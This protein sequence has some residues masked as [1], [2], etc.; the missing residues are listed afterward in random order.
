MR[1]RPPSN[2]LR[3]CYTRLG[4][5]LLLKIK[6]WAPYV[7]IFLA[8]SLKL[9]TDRANRVENEGNKKKNQNT[10]GVRVRCCRTTTERFS[11][12]SNVLKGSK[13]EEMFFF[14]FAAVRW[15]FRTRRGQRRIKD[16]YLFAGTAQILRVFAGF[17]NGRK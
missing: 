13:D 12:V 11:L 16:V 15:R 8:K 4:I 2:Y 9:G 17:K 6:N 3:C 14:L 7:Y 1:S 10:E 5:Y